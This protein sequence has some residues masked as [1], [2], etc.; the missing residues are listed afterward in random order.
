MR[1]GP[2]Y[3]VTA[4]GRRQRQQKQS[5]LDPSWDTSARAQKKNS[6]FTANSRSHYTARTGKTNYAP[7]I[8]ILLCFCLCVRARALSLLIS[9]EACRRACAPSQN[10]ICASRA[11]ALRHSRGRITFNNSSKY[12]MNNRT[13]AFWAPHELHTHT[14]LP[15]S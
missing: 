13:A 7:L 3:N 12:L 8:S 10:W 15:L 2:S 4:Q 1:S 5:R 14:P 11:K 6:E 9:K